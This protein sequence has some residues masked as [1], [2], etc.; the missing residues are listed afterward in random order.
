[1]RSLFLRQKEECFLQAV[2]PSSIN[3]GM[4]LISKANVQ[5]SISSSENC[6]FVS[7]PPTT[8]TS[9]V[10][11]RVKISAVAIMQRLSVN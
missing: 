7:L 9:H 1:M 11:Q 8:C 6:K 5:H 4:A 3:L 10:C 2:K